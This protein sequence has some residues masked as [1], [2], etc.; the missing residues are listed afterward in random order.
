M[1]NFAD[2]DMWWPVDEHESDGDRFGELKRV[3]PNARIVWPER[4]SESHKC[5]NLKYGIDT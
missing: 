3:H 4:Y 1:V 2:K 5:S